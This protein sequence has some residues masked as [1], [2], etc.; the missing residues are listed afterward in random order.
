[1]HTAAVTDPMVTVIAITKFK[2]FV[3]AAKYEHKERLVKMEQ[4]GVTF[5]NSYSKKEMK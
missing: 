1:M 5:I 2:F 4:N 3:L